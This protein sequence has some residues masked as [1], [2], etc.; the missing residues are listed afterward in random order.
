MKRIATVL[1]L[2]LVATL[3]AAQ[4]A[5]PIDGVPYEPIFHIRSPKNWINDPNGPYRDAVTGRIHYYFQYNPYG[6]L[7]GAINWYH[8]WSEDYAHWTRTGIAIPNDKWYDE[9]GV[10]SGT[11]AN[12]NF[13]V[14][15]A[16]YTCTE[17]VNIQRQC[18]ANIPKKDLEGHR[19]FTSFEK[20]ALN[21]VMTE[22]DVPNLVGTENF[23][24][25]TEWWLDP[26][27]PNRWLIAFVARIN[28]AEGDNAHVIVF[29]T[30]DPSHQSGY[31]FS[32]SLFVYKYDLDKMWECPDFFTVGSNDWYLKA[33]TMPSHRDFIVYGTYQKDPVSGEYVYVEDPTRSITTID[34]GQFYAS[35]TFYDPILKKRRLWGWTR[36]ELTDAQITEMGWSGVQNVL[37]DIVYDEDEGKLRYPP[38]PETNGA[39]VTK[40]RTEDSYAV[41]AVPV[42][43]I[44]PGA[45]ATK[46]H[47]INVKFEFPAG[48]FDASNYYTAATAPEIGVRIRDNGTR[49]TAVSVAMPA[50]QAAPIAGQA[51]VY[52][53]PVWKEYEVD[54]ATGAAN[55][56]AQCAE[57]R[58]C[59]GWA[60]VPIAGSAALN[61]RLQ[62]NEEES[63]ATAGAFSGTPNI[64]RLYFSRSES[65]TIGWT[66]RLN[67]R[68]PLRKST[69]TS[70]ELK[71]YVDDSIVEVY[72]DG[73]LET[74]SGRLYLDDPDSQLTGI[75][76]FTRNIP[77][78]TVTASVQVYTMG[79]IWKAEQ[80]N[81]VR[82]FTNSLYD[83][84]Y[85]LVV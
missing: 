30:E 82:N 46:Y 33:S 85:S 25:P 59:V 81:E 18:I 58:V 36:D 44:A 1:A 63:T 10:Y 21:P 75:S 41:T 28:D 2:A 32:H 65:G 39:R 19:L 40:L 13:S 51:P 57:E 80:P 60:V 68:A 74:M 8:V 24:D 12:N 84:L 54:A 6:P 62:W 5:A 42:Q 3:V 38:V 14:P 47:E 69:P 55:C 79:S 76:L 78:G 77:D 17:P 67:G 53:H 11:M 22:Y 37:R 71:I 16:I 64:P 83:L 34:Y 72:K 49:Y 52:K 70:F 73:G 43:V 15:V 7:W 48:T 27:N 45:G 50:A 29:S 35:K 31:K 23:R 61:C 66:D 20:S 26:E 9:W 56:S 4:A